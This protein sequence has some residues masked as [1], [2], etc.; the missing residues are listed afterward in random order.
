MAAPDRRRC[1]R[2]RPRRRARCCARGP[3]AE[4]RDQD[5]KRRQRWAELLD[6]TVRPRVP[7]GGGAVERRKPQPPRRGERPEACRLVL[8]RPVCCQTSGAD[9]RRGSPRRAS[10]STPFN[11][12]S[13]I[14]SAAIASRSRPRT[15]SPTARTGLPTR[16]SRNSSL[17]TSWKVDLS[18]TSRREHPARSSYSGSGRIP[19]PGS[20]RA[21]GAG[22]SPAP[23]VAQ[24]PKDDR[25]R[26]PLG[27]ERIQIQLPAHARIS[28]PSRLATRTPNVTPA[29]P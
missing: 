26:R 24:E 20:V 25:G 21:T 28:V 13:S 12:S 23:V 5:R 22:A 18:E 4:G 1:R 6:E 19:A 9:A 10:R 16:A 11:C 29:N 15:A 3:L 7:P 17:S 8:G 14:S 27:S 2:P